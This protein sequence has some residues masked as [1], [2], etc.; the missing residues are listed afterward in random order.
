VV[1]GGGASRLED[2][3]SRSDLARWIERAEMSQGR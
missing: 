2:I 3:I 1:A